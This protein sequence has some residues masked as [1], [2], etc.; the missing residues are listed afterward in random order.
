M[1]INGKEEQISLVI[2]Y[3]NNT[4]TVWLKA[5]NDYCRKFNLIEKIIDIKTDRYEDI[6]LI[7]FQLKLINKHMPWVNKIYLLLM[8]REQ[9]P[10]DLPP[11]VEII[12]HARFIPQKY[13]PTFNSTTIE[14]FLWNIPNLSEYF[15]YANDDMLPFKDLKPSDFFT[16]DGKIKIEWWNEDIRECRNVFR[17]QCVNSYKNMAVRLKKHTEDYKYIRPAHSFTPMIKSHCQT[18][19]RVLEDLIT[20]H[21]RAFR[22]EYQYNQYIYPIFEKFVYGTC[23]SKIDFLYTQ[24]KDDI[25]LDHDIVC[26]NIVP[27][28]KEKEL[29]KELERR[30]YE[31]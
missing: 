14:M 1:E 9:A 21:I 19:Y 11:N 18:A 26:I 13:L 27:K 2:P 23:D 30:T 24:L 20:R 5:Y 4:D 7:N 28:N 12:Y 22:T 6:G 29:L 25:D 3:V 10:K 15:I 17:Y 8:N 16:E 31:L